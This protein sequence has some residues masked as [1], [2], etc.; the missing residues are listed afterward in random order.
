MCELGGG[1]GGG[2]GPDQRGECRVE[3][4]RSGDV[5]VIVERAERPQLLLLYEREREHLP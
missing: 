1:G 2:G 3:S 4:G 5:R